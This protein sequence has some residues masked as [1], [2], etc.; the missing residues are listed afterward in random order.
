MDTQF[1]VECAEKSLAASSVFEKEAPRRIS[2][3]SKFPMVKALL[4][5]C[6]TLE[7]VEE[8]VVKGFLD[9]EKSQRAFDNSEFGLR[10][11]KES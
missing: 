2:Y 1:P 3:A 11:V 5:V 9:K 6:L 8:K 7:V 10:V 4:Q